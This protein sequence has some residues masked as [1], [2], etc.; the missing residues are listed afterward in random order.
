M[1][2]QSILRNGIQAI[3]VGLLIT[4]PAFSAFAA[5]SPIP[6]RRAVTLQN[7]DYYGG[8]IRSERAVSLE[9][10]T[11]ICAADAKC[12]AF[13]HNTRARACFLKSNYERTEPFKGAVSATFRDAD[14]AEIARAKERAAA[15]VFLGKAT[16]DGARDFA[17]RLPSRFPAPKLDAAALLAEAIEAV[18]AGKYSDAEKLYA[19][20]IV[21]S[22]DAADWLRLSQFYGTWEATYRQ[23]DRLYVATNAYLRSGDAEAQAT[24]LAEIAEALIELKQGRTALR[25]LK[26]ADA[27]A[28]TPEIAEALRKARQ[29]YG[30]RVSDHVVEADT[31]TPRICVEFTEPLAQSGVDY[32]PYVRVTGG[33]DLPVEIEERRLCIDG[34]THGENYRITL[35]S[36]LPAAEAGEAL[37]RPVTLEVYVRDRAPS[38]RF[39]GRDYVLPKTASAAIPVTTVNLD[40]VHLRIHRVTDRNL[41]R[42]VQEGMFG[43]RLDEY[44]EDNVARRLGSAVW[45]GVLEVT[46]E[47]NADTTTRILVAEVIPEFEPGVYVMTAREDDEGESWRDQATQWFVVTDTGLTTTLGEDG[48]HVFARALSTADAVEGTRLQLLAQNNEVL[49]EAVTDAEGYARFAGGLTRGTGGDAPALLIAEAEGGDFAFLD[50]TSGAFDLSDRGVEG[51]A[52]AGPVDVFVTTERGAYRPGEGVYATVLVRDAAAKAV[53]D[54]P[55]TAKVMRPDGVEY[56]SR[57]LGDEGAGGRALEFALGDAPMRGSWRLAVHADPKAP[58]LAAT[59]FLVEDFLPE[60]IDVLLSSA[61]DETRIGEIP[62]IN[63]ET[64]YLYGGAAAGLSVEGE[65]LVEASDA[66]EGYPGFRFGLA[67]EEFGTRIR[68]LET[69][70][71]TD[72]AG[73]VSVPMPLPDAIEST[74]PLSLT[75]VLRVRD[76]GGR[77][78]ERTLT[79]PIAGDGPRI[80]IKP[81]FEGAAK[82]G[83]D[84]QFDVIALDGAGARAALA[85][86]SWTLSR[87]E[88]RYQ[89]YRLHSEWNYEPVTRRTRIASGSIDINGEG[90][91][92]IASA[93]DW[94]SYELKLVWPEGERVTSSV[95]FA[96]G[97]YAPVAGSGTP[98]ILQVALDKP[99]YQIGDTA[100]LRLEA[101]FDGQALVQVVDRGLIA[102]QSVAVEAGETVIDLTVTDEWGPGAY[103]VASLLRPMDEAAKRNPSRAMGVA[104]A[105]VDPGA[106]KLAPRFSGPEEASPRGA[107][108]AS[109]VIPDLPAGT[110]AYVT[111]AAVD[112]GVLNVTGFE[113]PQPEDW[114]FGQRRL[115]VELRDLY[116]RLI[117]GMQGAEGKIR[118]GGGAMPGSA[119]PPPVEDIVA[120]FSG[121]VKTDAEG[122]AA[123]SFDLPDFNGTVRLMAIAWTAE[124]VGSAAQDVLVR[125][126]VVV[127]ATTPRFLAPGDQSRISLELAHAFGLAGAVS[128]AIEAGEGLEIAKEDIEHRLTLPE[129]GRAT[130]EIPVT[131]RSVGDPEIRLV[132]TAP[133]GAKLTKTLRLPVRA[134]DPKILRRST[135]PLAAGGT[136]TIDASAFAGLH[137]GTGRATLVVGALAQFDVAGVLNE[138]D[139]YPYGCTEQ[140]TSRALPLLYYSA[141]AETLGLTPTGAGVDTRIAQA[142]RRVLANQSS[143]GSFGLWYPSG[144]DFWLDAYVTDFLSRARAAGHEVPDAGFDAAMRN[145]RNRVAYSG[146]FEEGGEDLAYALMVLAREGEAS[147]GDLR[148]YADAKSEAFATAMAKAQ[149]GAALAMYGE[150]TRADRLFTLASA[151]ALKE[152]KRTGWRQDYGSARRDAASV[153][154][155]GVEAGSQTVARERLAD[156]ITITDDKRRYSSTQ[157]KVWTLLAANALVED[158]STAGLLINGAEINGPVIPMLDSRGLGG[159]PILIENAGDL[160]TSAML[161]VTGKP[162]EPEPAGGNG[163]A[164]MRSYFNMEGE[165]VD[166]A[167]VALNTRLVAVVE[168]QNETG[169]QG[170]LMIDDP[171]PAGFEIDNPSLLR[172]G[173]VAGLDWV[174][175]TSVAEYTGFQTDRFLAAVTGSERLLR[176]A[177]I[178]RAVSPGMFHHPAAQVEDMYRPEFRAR[179]DAGQVVIE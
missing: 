60:R 13:T 135:L 27:S 171:L 103:V 129:G 158:A 95:E 161:S 93:V 15:A 150:Q 99:S 76:G 8:D 120:F 107:L 71:V 25:A 62:S 177:Y 23:E 160:A 26:L 58:A 98:D 141:V 157:E 130:L 111:V 162:I 2:F 51:R 165:M 92:Q 9:A 104:W 52:A 73:K 96:A 94:G 34:A 154:A 106:R 30:F 68:P 101:R 57:V 179:T 146:E 155:L 28:S 109:L 75:A 72:P 117:D 169:R 167:S 168:V 29:N 78:V 69:S 89:W 21:L 54:L 149:L 156:L 140:T 80:G 133:N 64:V 36:G 53:G 123:I 59:S 55:I 81:L 115:G 114:F 110:D 178:V 100:K 87:I 119:S 163:Y 44:G 86:V 35:R 18:D 125:D 40:E 43:N 122:R 39:G 49:G 131:A 16:L 31:V 148:Y 170:R 151:H 118:S 70:Y 48:L 3:G 128:V 105:P 139:L 126:P 113:S 79:L 33:G 17:E 83:S 82:Q 142:I 175:E 153:L 10:C 24:A 14:A 47:L 77:P 84:A 37:Q 132:T 108:D 4:L 145:L 61:E 63:V 6:E 32:E 88:T 1:T 134:N 166:P 41:I 121:V 173:E 112:L 46:R 152:D 45:E 19:A 147:I 7:L 91:T 74:K 143:G 124:G 176:L 90:V 137:P 138:L 11:R 38:V 174:G 164:I 136:A 66:L 56:L 85:G 116:G 42:T 144:G 159:T 127:T 102:M 20:R 97:W 65:A 67:D 12:T 5:D 50:L 172:G 22:D